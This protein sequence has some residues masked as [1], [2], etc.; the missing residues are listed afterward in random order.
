MDVEGEADVK[1]ILG[2]AAGFLQQNVIELTSTNVETFLRES[3]SVPKVILFTDK[4]GV[5]TIFKGLSITFEVITTAECPEGTLS[6][7]Y[8]MGVLLIIYF[9][10]LFF[11]IGIAYHLLNYFLIL[12]LLII[13]FIK[14][15]FNIGIA[16]HL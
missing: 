7:L 2:L 16:Y 13:Y 9:V 14:L 6:D 10:K 5:P 8:V 11:N 15:F 1:K 12:A 3:E 4:T